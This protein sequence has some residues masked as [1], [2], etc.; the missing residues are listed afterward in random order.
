MR[1]KELG[2]GVGVGND[3]LPQW[4][5][6]LVSIPNLPQLLRNGVIKRNFLLTI[7]FEIYVRILYCV[8]LR[9]FFFWDTMPN[10]QVKVNRRFRVTYSLHLQDGRIVK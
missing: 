4:K 1:I 8:F 2:V 7:K 3:G 9:N 6:K 5:S 10:S